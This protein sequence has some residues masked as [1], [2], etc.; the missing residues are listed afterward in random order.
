MESLE[1]SIKKINRATV[2]KITIGF[3]LKSF[4][5]VV[6]RFVIFPILDS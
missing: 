3:F 2:G 5:A 1:N 4:S 6:N